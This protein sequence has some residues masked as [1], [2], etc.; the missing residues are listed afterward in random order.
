[1]VEVSSLSAWR[2]L[3]YAPII[4]RRLV[5][6]PAADISI[7]IEGHDFASGT[8]PS[9]VIPRAVEQRNLLDLYNLLLPAPRS[10]IL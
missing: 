1:M 3:R 2:T 5:Q 9:F 7:P 10:S 4:A 8:P 6:R